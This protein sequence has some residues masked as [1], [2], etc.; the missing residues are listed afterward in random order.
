MSADN[1]LNP[2]VRASTAEALGDLG[3]KRGLE[4][5]RAALKDDNRF[6][7]CKAAAALS[8]M[9]DNQGLAIVIAALEDP[10]YRLRIEAANA[11][12]CLARQARRPSPPLPRHWRI[13]M[14]GFRM[15]REKRS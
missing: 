10:D 14:V 11:L 4:P 2:Y 1:W 5:L 6:V 12:V 13:R 8:R 7:Q 9:G 3:D 15:P